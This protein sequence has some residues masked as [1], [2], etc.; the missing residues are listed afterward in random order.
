MSIDF[1]IADRDTPFLFPPSV[2]EWLPQD[3]LARFVVDMVSQLDL[4][5]L[6]GIYTGKG[7][8]PY[9]P[10]MLLS[11]LFYGYSTGVFSSRKL[12][13]ASYD[14]V[15]FRYITG[16]QHPDHD[17]IA[18]FRKRFSPELQR[19]F[20][21]ILIIAHEMGMLKLGTVSLDGT[22][23]QA[24]ASKHQALSWQYAC[25]LEKQLQEEVEQLWLFADQA[26]QA[27]IPDGM[28]IPE[29]LERREKRLATIAEAKR[30]IEARAAERYEQEKQA[31]ENKLAE[32]EKKA[33][34]SGK[35]SGGKPPK[36][37]VP[38]PKPQDQVN[39][40]DEESRI[41]PTSGGGFMQAFNAQACID[42]ASLLIVAAFTTQQPN[43]KQQIEPAIEAL[44]N[45]PDQLGQVNELIADTGFFSQS[46]V[47]ACEAADISPLIA[48]GRDKHNPSIEDRFSESGPMVNDA[49]SVSKMKNRLKSKEGKA[50][51]AKRKCT[52][53]PVFGII[54][55]VLGYRQ[56]MRRGLE[57]ANAEWT[58]V[59]LAW[60]LKR[61]HVLAKPRLKIPVMAAYKAKS[62]VQGKQLG[63]FWCNV[64]LQW[65]SM[66]NMYI[67]RKFEGLFALSFSV[68]R[69]T[70]C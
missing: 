51:Y 50:I 59:S 16:N 48:V 12:E 11:M 37:P 4:S 19:L 46:N 29:E 31:Y 18:T 30:K 62:G 53:E 63:V 56:F 64:R 42:I 57:N 49:D 55:S 3:H 34:E 14:S 69:P 13:Q 68:I 70:G 5:S 10:M 26:D 15:A 66:A 1:I 58:L 24:N 2:Q 25:K 52:V 36:P 21:Q 28:K 45:L 67:K 35:K 44:E 7:S 23:V 65:F 41:M 54:K 6:R 61:M 22:K 17:T 39:L 40:T 32:R 20:V 9:D 27:A 38:G 47:D 8:R 43:D 33:K 60:N